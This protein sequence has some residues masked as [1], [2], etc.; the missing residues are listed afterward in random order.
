[1]SVGSGTSGVGGGFTVSA[2]TTTD[3]STNRN[4]GAV[5]ITTGQGTSSSGAMTLSTGDG[6]PVN[7]TQA[8]T[9]Y[10]SGAMTMT[11]GNS[12]QGIDKKSK[13]LGLTNLTSYTTFFKANRVALPLV[14]GRRMLCRQL[15]P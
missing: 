15:P 8:T 14:R 1:M 3:T 9:S 5:A 7:P 13:Y 11:T 12:H 2:G 10:P 4:G 6:Q